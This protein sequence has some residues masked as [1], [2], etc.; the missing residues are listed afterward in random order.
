MPHSVTSGSPP[1][2]QQQASVTMD[3]ATDNVASQA[4]DGDVAMTDA[5]TAE[6]VPVT[7]ANDKKEVKLEELFADVDSDDEFPSSRPNETQAPSSPPTAA[8]R[9][10]T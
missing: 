5:A 4:S 9:S 6:E 8:P 2:D 3:E 10:P 7:D 1:A